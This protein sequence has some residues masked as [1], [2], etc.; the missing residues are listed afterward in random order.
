M[1]GVLIGPVDPNEIIRR[2]IAA[3]KAKFEA[4]QDMLKDV[5]AAE[6]LEADMSEVRER[7]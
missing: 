5:I 2:Y 4:E 7:I 6:E 3:N 1:A